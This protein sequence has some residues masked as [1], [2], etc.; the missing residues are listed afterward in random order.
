MKNT[1]SR[2]QP[3]VVREMWQGK[4]WT[5]RPAIMIQDNPELIALYIHANISSKRRTG[6]NGDHITAE[7]RKNNSWTLREITQSGVFHCIRLTIPGES[8]SVLLFWNT[9]DNN[10]RYWYINLE[11]PEIPMRRTA[12]GFDCFDRILDLIIQPD[13]KDWRWDNED[14][15]REAVE[16][17]L[18]S[19]EQAKALYAKGEDVRDLIMSGKS[20]FNGWENWNPDPKWSLP[21]LQ[22][23]W[24][25]V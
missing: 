25:V 14:E 23:G 15:L 10:L 18:I 7:E 5:A 6:L 13:L 21:V 20:I 9:K 4:I 24:D 11:D 8:Y 17:G 16:V 22:D 19:A 2:G 1:F 3:I 12:I